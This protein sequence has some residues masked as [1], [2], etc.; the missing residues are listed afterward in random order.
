M[1]SLSL[2]RRL[3]SS[4]S[5][6]LLGSA[7]I[8]AKGFDR[9][10][11]ENCVLVFSFSLSLPLLVNDG[12]GNDLSDL[13]VGRD[14]RHPGH[15]KGINRVEPQPKGISSTNPHLS[16][17]PIILNLPK[18]LFAPKMTH[19]CLLSHPPHIKKIKR[20]IHTKDVCP[21]RRPNNNKAQ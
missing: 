7:F 12:K 17:A 2:S 11:G 5:T 21:S 6:R 9:R 18:N 15:P 19:F 16:S 1:L 13:L 14:P 10:A 3:F 20:C 4:R 8:C